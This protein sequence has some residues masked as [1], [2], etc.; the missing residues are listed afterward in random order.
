M[1]TIAL[2]TAAADRADPKGAV[3]KGLTIPA[4]PKIPSRKFFRQ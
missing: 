2:K 4:L 3:A 1:S